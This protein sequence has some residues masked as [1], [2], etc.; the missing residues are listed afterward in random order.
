M[1]RPAIDAVAG[2]GDFSTMYRWNLSVVK[3]PPAA[4]VDSD[5]LN[6]RC[7]STEMPKVTFTN[8]RVNVRGHKV[9]Q[10]G[11]PDYIDTLTFIFA[12]TVDNTVMTFIR[13]WREACWEA[14]KGIAQTQDQIKGIFRIARLNSLDEEIY[15]YVLNGCVLNDYDPGGTWDGETSDALKPN[16][17]IQY[18]FFEDK[19][20]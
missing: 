16:L 2:I 11:V 18:D 13:N 14:K 9:I 8:F 6:I 15:E 19:E 4:A 20:L 5:A 7:L 12:E 17:I 1:V 10:T 3:A